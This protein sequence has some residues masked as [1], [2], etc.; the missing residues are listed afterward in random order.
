MYL[1]Y[2]IFKH[3]YS[4]FDSL[5]LCLSRRPPATRRNFIDIGSGTSQR[6]HAIHKY[7]S[8]EIYIERNSDINDLFIRC[9]Y[10]SFNLPDYTSYSPSW[11]D[12]ELPVPPDFCAY[13][14]SQWYLIIT[15]RVDFDALVDDSRTDY[16]NPKI[17]FES[18][19]SLPYVMELDMEQSYVR[20]W[21]QR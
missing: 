18:E 16:E 20:R 21:T 6:I 5:S 7:K 2:A 8:S 12:R 1:H 17:V 13:L 9:G 4:V 14:N 15:G 19:I 3:A 10:N 11:I